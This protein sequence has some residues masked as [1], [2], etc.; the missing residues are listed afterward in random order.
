M[1]KINHSDKTVFETKNLRNFWHENSNIPKIR[2]VKVFGKVKNSNRTF[3]VIFKHCT[4]T[5]FLV[6]FFRL[7]F[8]VLRE[9]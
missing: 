2:S 7:V 4:P 9:D 5:L 3:L 8:G 6:R 1:P